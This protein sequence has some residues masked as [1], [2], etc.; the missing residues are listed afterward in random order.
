MSRDSH[1]SGLALADLA[2]DP[3]EEFARWFAAAEAEPG[4]VFAEAVCLSTLG[5]EDTPEG[6]MVLLKHFDA[7]GFVFYTNLDSHKGRALAAHPRAGLT[8]YWQP[9]GRQV[10]IRGPVEPVSPGEADAY[11]ASRPRESRIGAWASDQSRGLESRAAL[12]RRAAE[13]EV[14]FAGGDVPRPPNWSGFRIVPE[15]IEFWQE[16][17]ARLHDRFIYER[18]EAGGWARRRLYP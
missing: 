10:R 18:D 16:G 5:P 12:E 7:C 17:S 9:L 6:R 2:S 4:I 3:L 14:R 8:F 11:F 1:P 13:L 15:A